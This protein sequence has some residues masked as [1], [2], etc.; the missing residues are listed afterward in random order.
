MNSVVIRGV[1]IVGLA[2]GLGAIGCGDDDDAD[3]DC[4]APAG[5]YSVEVVDA[6]GDCDSEY[7][8]QVAGTRDWDLDEEE[9]RACG[10]FSD[11]YSEAFSMGDMSC[12]LT[13]QTSATATA[14]GIEDASFFATFECD[15]EL[16]C[17][18]DFNVYFEYR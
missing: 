10:S 18:H 15:G 8:D 1:L 14:S 9:D 3:G 17:E 4:E 16:V 2:L 11:T 13:E 7:V 12:T 5:T 6:G